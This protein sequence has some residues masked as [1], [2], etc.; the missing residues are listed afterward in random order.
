[1]IG[2]IAAVA[3]GVLIAVALIIVVQM[4]GHAIYPPPTGISG[5]DPDALAAMVAE[6]PAGALLFVIL[7]YVFGVFGG[8]MLAALVARQTP[9][10]YASIVGAFVLAGTIMNL[11]SITHP[12]W[13]GVTS[14]VAI[15]ATVL[16]TGR[17]A[18]MMISEK[19]G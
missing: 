6:A 8:G 18:P 5:N 16:L 12:L 7:S 1:M 4:I 9:L 2:R 13:F 14:V 3:F 10:M 19:Q 11:Y 15:I 17:I